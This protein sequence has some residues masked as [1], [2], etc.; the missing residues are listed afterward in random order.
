MVIDKIEN[1]LAQ[2]ITKTLR[3]E[4]NLDKKNR[5]NLKKFLKNEEKNLLKNKKYNSKNLNIIEKVK[6]NKHNYNSYEIKNII[7][8]N[9]LYDFNLV[10]SKMKN[11]RP[12][13]KQKKEK[14][15]KTLYNNSANRKNISNIK[16]SNSSCYLKEKYIQ[17]IA[18]SIK[19]KQNLLSSYLN[20]AT[21]FAVV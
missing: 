15:I 20:I 18:P 14:C 7:E 6:K 12:R 3:N 10:S 21:I 11:T 19:R 1:N 4:I 8:S 13:D 16:K 2:K 5:N 9:S 17:I